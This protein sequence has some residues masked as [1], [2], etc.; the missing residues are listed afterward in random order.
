ML[1]GEAAEAAKVWQRLEASHPD[2]RQQA[3]LIL[4]ELSADV[5][6]HK[7]DADADELAVTRSFIEWYQKLIRARANAV[8][9]G[10]NAR[11]EKL[12]HVLPTAAHMIE[13]AL[14]QADNCVPA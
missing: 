7:L 6:V 10:V 1:H 9:E 5:P 2:I 11:L 8:V 3:A 14:G 12:S 4:C 13:A